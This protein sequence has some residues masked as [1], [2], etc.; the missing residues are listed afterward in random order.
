MLPEIVG[1]ARRRNKESSKPGD[2]PYINLPQMIQKRKF[3][4]FPAAMVSVFAEFVI[5]S[6]PRT[7]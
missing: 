7:E 6:S 4:V 1:L 3:I 5:L 2:T